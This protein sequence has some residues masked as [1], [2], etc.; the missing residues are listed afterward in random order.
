MSTPNFC[1][2]CGQKLE[3]GQ[4]FCPNCGQSLEQTVYKPASS[5][6]SGVGAGLNNMLSGLKEN[7]S[8]I[9]TDKI[10]S[11]A[12]RVKDKV[13]ET[14]ANAKAKMEEAKQQ[15]MQWNREI[16]RTKPL[17]IPAD[18]PDA[19]I[20]S[21]TGWGVLV[22]PNTGTKIDSS[23]RGSKFI[24]TRKQILFYEVPL[25]KELIP[26]AKLIG[27]AAS[28]LDFTI[29]LAD[30]CSITKEYPWYV[31]T[32]ADGHVC[33][34]EAYS[35]VTKFAYMLPRVAGID[36]HLLNIKLDEGETIVGATDAHIKKKVTGILQWVSA[37]I[38]KTN[39]RILINSSGTETAEGFT[40]ELD[41]PL[42]QITS[43]IE[44]AGQLNCDYTM[45]LKDGTSYFVK[46]KGQTPNWFL[47]MCEN[48][49]GNADRLAKKGKLM[50][51]LKV[52]MVVGT[53]AAAVAGCD[54]DADVDADV[55]A[56]MD[57]DGDM[58]MDTVDLDGDGIDDAVVADF[59]G[60]GDFDAI[61]IDSDGDGDIDTIGVDTDGDGDIDAIGVDSD[62]DGDI[63]A[64]GA[65]TDGD[66]DLDTIGVDTDGDGAIDTVGMD[67]DGDG[68]LDTLGVDSDGDGAI[69][70]VGMDTDGD[71]S[72]DTVAVDA[73]GDGAVDVVGFDTDGDGTIDVVKEAV[74]E[75]A[76]SDGHIGLAA[77][78]AGAALASEVAASAEEKKPGKKSAIKPEPAP[79]PTPEQG[80]SD[81]KKKGKGGLIAGIIAA[82]VV[83][84][85]LGAFLFSGHSKQK[86]EAEPAP[87][88]YISE[89]EPEEAA[90]EVAADRV[91]ACAY[92]GYINIRESAT[93]K[94]PVLGR[95]NN[96]PE[97]AVLL[98]EEGEWTK[99]DLNGITGYVLSKYVQD[100]PTVAY[101]GTATAD[102]L[103]GV[104]YDKE[105]CSMYYFYNN[106]YY[107]GPWAEGSDANC[108]GRYIMQ[109][110][111]VVLYLLYE[112]YL[113]SSENSEDRYGDGTPLCS[114]TIDTAGD[115]LGGMER[116]PWN[117]EGDLD[118]YYYAR[119]GSQ[120]E[121][122]AGRSKI[123][124]DMEAVE[125]EHFAR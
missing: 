117:F 114:F 68:N 66:G 57:F 105:D 70:T 90:P 28:K 19:Q 16:V 96:G 104:W 119:T 99:V 65:D 26:G 79:A 84:G 36:G 39:K 30:I 125:R 40:V 29:N 121:F 23:G 33:T 67:A 53:V 48:A 98:G 3:P 49:T 69:D 103:E 31:L 55:D 13:V 1:P 46:F 7:I 110:N 97:G 41:T 60:D 116:L 45:N 122:R 109:D 61:G 88:E 20:G 51:G 4:K 91:Y 58:E 123:K 102:W 17:V 85:G 22:D 89:A 11:A 50:K 93:S 43:I 56:D 52:A 78:V 37:S 95:F 86:E 124:A 87:A 112:L 118:E 42:D 9:D 54:S 21:F 6:S 34:V 12:N 32:L 111:E 25:A 94:S 115:K 63:D 38:I 27:K 80:P 35:K 101:T 8:K 15:A 62:G 5:T 24:V 83:L 100:T 81:D 75:A 44:N 107:S 2:N 47:S 76:G 113:I 74:A 92:D 18:N 10:K 120:E 71:G 106:G 59:D 108:Y 77:A 72:I 82:V 64:F 14:A 73:D